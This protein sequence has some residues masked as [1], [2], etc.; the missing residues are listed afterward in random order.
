[1]DWKTAGY[2]SSLR[3]AAPLAT[4]DGR[5]FLRVSRSSPFGIKYWEIGNECYGSWETDYHRPAMGSGDLCARRGQD[6]IAKMKAV[7]PTIK[8]GVV[9]RW[10]RTPSIR[11]RPF[12]TSPIRAPVSRTTAGRLC[13]SRLSSQLGVTPDFLIYHR[14]E[15]A[16]G[17]ETD[18]RSCCKPR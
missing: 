8:I 9:A 16:P 1:M 2:W 11:S 10:A 6:Y 7:D 13:C 15:Q 4:D 17:Q 14:Y 18:A 3:A 12:T 5:N